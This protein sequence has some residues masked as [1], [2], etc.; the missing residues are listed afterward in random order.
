MP[1][2]R[3][4]SKTRLVLLGLLGVVLG[5]AL[6]VYLFTVLLVGLHG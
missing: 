2:E 6:V 1:D 4:P 5:L 3:P